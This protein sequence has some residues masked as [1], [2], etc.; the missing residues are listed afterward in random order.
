MDKKPDIVNL[1]PNPGNG[2]LHLWLS[3]NETAD[4]QVYNI[5]G[6]K[7]DEL[8]VNSTKS[9]LNLNHLSEGIYFVKVIQGNTV[10][11]KKIVITK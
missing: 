8:H 3:S 11:T 1:F 2:T 6:Q 10:N 9:T 5:V 7:I 4:V